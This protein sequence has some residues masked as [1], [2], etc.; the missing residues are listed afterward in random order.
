[1]R[2]TSEPIAKHAVA[3]GEGALSICMLLSLYSN[4]KSSMISPSGPK[5][6]AL[7]PA[8]P[9]FISSELNYFFL[10]IAFSTFFFVSKTI[11]VA[12]NTDE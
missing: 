11:G 6:I 5:A 7:T 12:I 8:L 10:A 1:M 3:A 9:G 2:V 4:L